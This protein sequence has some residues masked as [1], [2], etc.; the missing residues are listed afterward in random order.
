MLFDLPLADFAA[1]ANAPALFS[2]ALM[3]LTCETIRSEP[4]MRRLAEAARV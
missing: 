2:V 3:D 4:E 1:R